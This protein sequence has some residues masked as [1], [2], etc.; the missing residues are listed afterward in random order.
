MSIFKKIVFITDV[1]G[2]AWNSWILAIFRATNQVLNRTSLQVS[3]YLFLSCSW[4]RN[5]NEH[6]GWRKYFIYFSLINLIII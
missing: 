3:G 4:S 2:A 1:D 6:N 5:S